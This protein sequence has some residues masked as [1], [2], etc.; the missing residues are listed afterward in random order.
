[1][2]RSILALAILLVASTAAA[3]V[4]HHRYVVPVGPGPNAKL[5]IH[6]V[7]REDGHGRQRPRPAILLMHGDFATFETNFTAMADWLAEHD[8]DVWGLDRRWTQAGDDLS[9]F[10]AMGI[11]Q[12][13][14]DIGLA[15]AFARAVRLV[16]DGSH[17]RITLSGFSRGGML[18]YFYASREGAQPAWR[19]HVKGLVPL[20]V[21]AS[22][23]P[24]DEDLRQF[25]CDNAAREYAR[26]AAGEVEE[27]NEFQILTGQLAI[28]A[29]DEQSPFFPPFFAVTNREWMLSFV[30]ETY[31]YFGATPWYH[32]N[33]PVYDDRFFVVGLTM[34]PEDVV[35]RWLAGAPP[36]QSLR[37]EADT[38]ALIC[39]DDP[40]LDL[41]LSNIRVPVLAL[42]A[43]GGY[44]EAALDSTTRTS[45]TDVTA[46]VIRRLPPE[47][48]TLDFGHADL[49]FSPDAPAL[50]WQPLLDW[51]RDRRAVP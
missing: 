15:L 2:R 8:V 46:L 11:D 20:D 9:D 43:A 21:Y 32:L 7:V 5:T 19:R 44:G 10:D 30:G 29:P 48:V 27:S 24:E 6:R 26:L 14:D 13:L 23:A 34:S 42:L 51:L 33:A 16:T 31:F 1:M 36:H 45:S 18:A 35:A 28:D 40:P 50:A 39:G 3:D 22:L 25:N 41:P 12:E 47:D 49:L 17:D 37:E 4:A 38:D